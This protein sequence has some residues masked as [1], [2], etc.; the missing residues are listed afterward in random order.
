MIYTIPADLPD[1]PQCG[2]AIRQATKHGASAFVEP[3]GHYIPA[4]CLRPAHVDK[5]AVAT[6]GGEDR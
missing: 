6:D 5:A 2:E 4:R 3:C 1:C